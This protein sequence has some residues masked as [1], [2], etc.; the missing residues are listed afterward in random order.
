MKIGTTI[1]QKDKIGR[2]TYK[3]DKI[4]KQLNPLIR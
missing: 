4:G 2:L 3:K 1:Y